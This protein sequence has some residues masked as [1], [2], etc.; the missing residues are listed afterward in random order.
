MANSEPFNPVAA[1]RRI[2][3][4]ARTGGLATLTAGGAPFAS[5]VTVATDPRGAPT[6]LLSGLAAH[7]ANLR[8]D[9][10][11][12]LLLE[13]RTPGD[14]LQIGRISVC[15]VVTRLTAPD[16]DGVR[17]RFLARQPEAVFYAGFKDFD[18]WRLMPDRIHLVAGFGRIVDLAAADLLLPAD[19]AARFTAAEERLT[20]TL[21]GPGDAAGMPAGGLAGLVGPGW[22]AVGVDPDGLDIARDDED[23]LRL[24]R[25]SF[26]RLLTATNQLP[27]ILQEIATKPIES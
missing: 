3:R 14:P 21:N 4:R 7:T 26:P 1:A 9:P 22:R 8:G 23:G 2:L 11:A 13:A 27:S 12:S 20:A 18:Y 15:G 25:L 5:L 10:R 24:D 6:M 16:E 17:R 19:L